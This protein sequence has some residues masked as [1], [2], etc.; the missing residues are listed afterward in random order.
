MSWRARLSRQVQ[1]IR[2]NICPSSPASSGA[3]QFIE[4]EYLE[5]KT[6]NPRLP[7]LV[8]EYDNKPAF[9][10]A[11]YDFGEEKQISIDNKS[12]DE[13]LNDLKDVCLAGDS[14]PRS[15]ESVP[16]DLDIVQVFPDDVKN[17]VWYH[18]V[19]PYRIH[20]AGLS[21]KYSFFF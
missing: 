19:Y 2:F 9:L 16:R 13:I 21:L 6:L 4:R 18:S 5:F 8:R 12:A 10:I 7:F 11:R 17:P 3:I 20:Y 14:F 15:D 1:E